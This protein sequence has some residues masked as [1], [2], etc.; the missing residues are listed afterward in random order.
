MFKSLIKT[1]SIVLLIAISG[2]LL[3]QV[4]VDSLG[5]GYN[6]LK[7]AVPF[8]TIAP[9]SRAGAMGD[10]GAATQPD[11][12]AQHWN[13]AK[14]PFLNKKW[15]VSFSYTPWLRN[16]VDDINLTYLAGFYKVDNLQTVSGSL[17]Y[18]AMGEVYF[19]NTTGQQ[20]TTFN[21]NEFALDFG[22]SRKFS[23][24]ISGALAFR[25]IRSDL[26]GGYTQQGQA[27]A[28]AGTA[29]AADIAMYFQ[30]PVRLDGKNGEMAFGANIS[31]IGSKLSYNDDAVK[32]FI[33]INMRL[34]G[35]ITIN[36]DQYN[37]ISFSL[38]ANKLLVPTPPVYATVDGEE[39]I[40]AGKD[41]NVSIVQGMIQSFYD[42]PDGMK[43][44]LQEISYS[45]GVEYWYAKQFALRAGYFYENKYKGNRKY[46]TLGAGLKYNIFNIDFAYLIPSGGFNSPMAN[47]LRFSL[48]FDFEPAR[49]GKKK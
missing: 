35:R 25:Y 17:R 39:T 4:S 2:R 22:Y 47:T 10:I 11:A 30:H 21:P 13:P 23:D 42:A 24:Y 16:L 20:M 31:N 26:T 40:V 45:T 3:G 12:N 19:T 32:D 43:E 14:Y 15:G 29:F 6:A 5:G 28:K 27:S 37:T 36:Y 48:S 7:V 1:V 34:G 41:P 46:F 44:E 49:A 9:D 8:L 38:D 33:P 18:F